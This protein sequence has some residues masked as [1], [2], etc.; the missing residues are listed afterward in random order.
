MIS[1]TCL[2]VDNT[3]AIAPAFGNDSTHET[4][5]RVTVKIRFLGECVQRKIIMIVYIKSV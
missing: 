5:K 2:W 3:T 4:V 1:S